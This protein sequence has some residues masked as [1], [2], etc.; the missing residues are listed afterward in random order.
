MPVLHLARANGW[1]V[2]MALLTAGVILTDSHEC[3]TGPDPL[4]C[5]QA[6]EDTKLRPIPPPYVGHGEALEK[7]LTRGVK[8]KPEAEE[9]AEDEPE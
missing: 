1:P 7:G 3:L 9:E 5:L 4:A 8:I 2:I 6:Q